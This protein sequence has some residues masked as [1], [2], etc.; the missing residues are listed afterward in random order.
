MK[1]IQE[2]KA[3][4][5]ERQSQEQNQ[6]NRA[7]IGNI[8][9]YENLTTSKPTRSEFKDNKQTFVALSFHSP[10]GP[11]Y[12]L[13]IREEKGTDKPLKNQPKNSPQ[14]RR[15]AFAASRNKQ[16]PSVAPPID[17]RAAFAASR[18]KKDAP[19]PS[20]SSFGAKSTLKNT[21][22]DNGWKFH[23]SI[24]QSEANK[25]KAW[26]ALVPLLAEYKV[27]EAKITEPN[28]T[29]PSNKVITIYTFKGGPELDNWDAFIQKAEQAL[30]DSSVKPG[31]P[32]DENQINGSRYCYY[33]NDT[34]QDGKY[35]TEN[36]HIKNDHFEKI[37]VQPSHDSSMSNRL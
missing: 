22:P 3:R 6:V 27:G 2:L 28:V 10:K 34:G 7:D 18:A 20:T 21:S 16:S 11:Y 26:D 17:R 15:A 29:T 1:E 37:S 19:T 30:T 13:T 24:E 5:K 35:T 23:L 8:Y 4:I 12:E 36:S 14:G 9:N 31:P 32:I 25:A 33:R